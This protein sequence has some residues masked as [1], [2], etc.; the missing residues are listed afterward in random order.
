[1]DFITTCNWTQTGTFTLK[2]SLVSMNDDGFTLNFIVSD[3][4]KW[5]R[6]FAIS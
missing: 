6:W 4:N 1:M 5:V 2:A 3:S